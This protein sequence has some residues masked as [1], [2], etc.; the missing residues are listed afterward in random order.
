MSSRS[1]SSQLWNTLRRYTEITGVINRFRKDHAIGS[2]FSNSGSNSNEQINVRTNRKSTAPTALPLMQIITNLHRLFPLSFSRSFEDFHQFTVNKEVFQENLL[3]VL[4]YYPVSSSRYTADVIRTPVG[5][6]GNYINEF[7]ITPI[8]ASHGESMAPDGTPLKHIILVHGYGAGLGFFIKNFN[9]LLSENVV[10]HAI[11][12]PGYGFSSRP[13]FPFSYPKDSYLAVENYFHDMLH[14]WFEQKGL[15]R[16]WE[17]NFVVAHSMGAYIFA[18]YANK[19]K[20]FRKLV[21]CSPGGVS[22]NESMPSPPWWFVKLWDRNISPF[23]LVRNSGRLGSKLVSGWSSRRFGLDHPHFEKIHRYTYG[24]FNQPG[25][26]EYMLSFML[27]CGGWPRVP[28]ES[29][30]FTDKNFKCGHLDWLWLYGDG[31]WMD[32]NGGRRINEFLKKNNIKSSL[33]VVPDA[34]HHLYWDN[35]SFFND[36]VKRE[37]IKN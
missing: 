36:I 11:D 13:K 31:D 9:A 10:I 35:D 25:S 3:S 16:S 18:L 4:P 22:R 2:S 20:H 29:R 34:G 5:D 26:G 27:G 19:Y 32:V 24:I 8:R 6:S 7:Q 21:M 17:S 23:S 28:L 33:A 30:L 14:Q 1:S 12:L 15:T 37:I